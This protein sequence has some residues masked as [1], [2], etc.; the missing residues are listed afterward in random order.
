LPRPLTSHQR[1]ILQQ[2]IDMDGEAYLGRIR[3]RIKELTGS[4]ISLGRASDLLLR[5]ETRQWIKSKVGHARMTQKR[6]DGPAFELN[7]RVKFYWIL[8]AGKAVLGEVE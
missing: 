4:D 1:N 2:V 6:G 8:P 5:M 3:R 7:K